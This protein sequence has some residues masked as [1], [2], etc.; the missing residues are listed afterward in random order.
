MR[1]LTT[2][3]VLAGLLCATAGLGAQEPK[4]APAGPAAQEKVDFITPHIT[5][6]HHIELPWFKPPFAK[7]V[8]LPRW[9]PVHIGKFAVDLSPTKHVVFLLL[10]ATLASLVLVG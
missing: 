2:T 7:E 4:A 8:E 9:A 3:A 10:G 6:A 1:R 5:D